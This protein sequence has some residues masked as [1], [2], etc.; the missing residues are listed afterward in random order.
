MKIVKKVK[1]TVRETVGVTVGGRWSMSGGDGGGAV[2]VQWGCQ[3]HYW[4][5]MKI[6]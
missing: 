4:N 1:K 3:S 2:E 6:I 5:L